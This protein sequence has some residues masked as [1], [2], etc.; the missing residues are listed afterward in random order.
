MLSVMEVLGGVLVFGGIA[1]ADVAALHA[2]T[3]MNPAVAHLQ[4]LLADLGVS[5]DGANLLYVRAVGH[6]RSFR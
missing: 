4:T 3:E 1:T 5:L 2:Q 6:L